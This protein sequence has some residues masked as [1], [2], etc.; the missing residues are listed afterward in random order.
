MT[1]FSQGFSFRNFTTTDAF[2]DFQRLL[3]EVQRGRGRRLDQPLERGR[4]HSWR[5]NRNPAQQRRNQPDGT[6]D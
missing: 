5:E 2:P 4:E 6:L 3:R 1:R